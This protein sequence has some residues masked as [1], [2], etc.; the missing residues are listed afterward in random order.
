MLIIFMFSKKWKDALTLWSIKRDNKDKEIFN[1]RGKYYY[2]GILLQI[3]KKGKYF[4]EKVLYE[5]KC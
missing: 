2:E 5:I 3:N 4:Y 1:I